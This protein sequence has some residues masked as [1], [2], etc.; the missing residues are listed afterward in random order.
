MTNQAIEEALATGAHHGLLEDYFG[1]AHYAELRQLARQAARATRGGPRV[2]ILPGIMGSKLGIRRSLIWDDI[3]W[4]DPLDIL[5]GRLQSLALPE[6]PGARIE[7]LGVLLLAYAKLKLRLR[8]AGFDAEFSAFDWRQGIPGLGAALAKEI[9]KD[10]RPVHLVAHSMG[11]LVARA[12][13][14]E[15][16]GNLKRI[17]TLGTP[18]YGSYAPI[19]AFRGVH[20]VVSKVALLDLANSAEDL[21]GIFKTFP[22]LCQMLPMPPHRPSFFHAAAWPS[23]GVR[24]DAAMLVEAQAAQKKLPEHLNDLVQIVGCNRQTVV[25]ASI[26]NHEF[27]YTS[28]LDGDGTVPLDLAILPN[29]RTYYIEEEH[30]SLPN[31]AVVAEAVADILNS[32]ATSALPE[33]KPEA[34]RGAVVTTRESDLRRAIEEQRRLAAAGLAL[35][36]SPTRAQLPGTREARELLEGFAS[37]P[38]A[39]AL[40]GVLT[41]QTANAGRPAEALPGRSDHVVVGRRNQHRLDITIAHGSVLD[42]DASAY[43]LGIFNQV[44]P[45]G[46]A[47]ELDRIMDG[48]ISQMMS[49]RMLAGNIGEITMLPRG[50]HPL[51]PDFVAFAALG[52][53][54]TFNEQTLSLVAENLIRTLVASRVD[55]FATVAIGVGSGMMTLVSLTHMLTGFVRGLI[56]ADGDHHFRGITVCEIDTD[57]YEAIRSELYRLCATSLFENVEV[58]L[59]ERRLPPPQM[60]LA[61]DAAP[62][63]PDPAYLIVREESVGEGPK[64]SLRYRCSVLPTGHNAT[65]WSE[66][67]DLV[68]AKEVAALLDSLPKNRNDLTE[69]HLKKI[70]EELGKV[71]LPMQVRQILTDSS[72]RDLVVIHDVNASRIPW[73]AIHVAGRPLVTE[74][75]LSH[76]YEAENLSIAKWLTKRHLGDRLAVLLAVDPTQDLVG[77]RE[78]GR[79]IEEL[80]KGLTGVASLEVLRGAQ[81]TRREMLKRFES[82]RYDVLHYS[83]HSFFDL[84]RREQSGLI[85]HGKEVLS[86]ADLAPLANLPSLVFFNSCESARVRLDGVRDAATVSDTVRR[87]EGVAEAL[88]RG[89]IANFIGT[90]WPV[91]DEPASKFAVEFYTAVLRGE[92]LG[93]AVLSARKVV[94]GLSSGSADWADYAF[95]G[96]AHFSLK[97]KA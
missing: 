42:V 9:E 29:K 81:V 37:P 86:G 83:G 61:A 87:G 84:R 12:A 10:G 65:V 32:G 20:S 75:W 48:A 59:R 35:D 17:V 47:A 78:E 30:G 23:S 4:I 88:L 14:K 93:D 2:L 76:R 11:G 21:A 91:R 94:R 16:P 15:K 71:A 6:T 63:R 43:V 50:R 90:Y 62:I 82:G 73:D 1:E 89:G 67:T 70:G 64:E 46:P 60:L 72:Y 41:P 39:S 34:A 45:T 7:P 49:R 57:R 38:S 19:Q 51:R 77:A 27:V 5:I 66:A 3:L 97:K 85:M 58:T 96:D 33:R 55:D 22:G 54:D 68:P 24:P 95:Y 56:D 92:R 13:F 36:G 8:T 44:S 18:N 52:G 40:P 31:N 69:E 25:G 53:F 26:A 74:G 80:F 28:T 79:R